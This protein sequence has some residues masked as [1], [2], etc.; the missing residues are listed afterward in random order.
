MGNLVDDR[1]MN[2]N[3]EQIEPIIIYGIKVITKQT[4]DF[5]PKIKEKYN[6]EFSSEFEA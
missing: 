2:I 4:K 1:I 5:L 6:Q 3:P